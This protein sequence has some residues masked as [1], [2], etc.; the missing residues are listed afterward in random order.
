[1]SLKRYVL[2]ALLFWAGPAMAQEVLTV[3]EAL[4]LAYANNPAIM[5][6]SAKEE[7]ARQQIAQASAAKLPQVGASLLAQFSKDATTYGVYGP[8][9]KIGEAYA[10][11]RNAYQAALTLNWLIYSS[12]SVSNTVKARELALSGVEAQ[13]VR[14]GQGVE[15]GVRK[16]YYG[17]QRARAKLLVAEEALSLAKEHLTQV[18]SFY[19]YGVVAKDQVLRVQVDVSDGKLNV[20]KAANAVDVGWSAL[21]RA[22]G[23]S[24]KKSYSLPEPEST[25]SDVSVPD[26]PDSFAMEQRPELTALEFSRLSALS[27][28][29]A[30]SGT[31]G[32]QVAVQGRV[33]DTD[34]AFFP[35]GNDDWSVSLSASWTFFDGGESLAKEKE[36]KAAAQE[37]V[38]SIEDLK[39][40]IS[41]EISSGKLN[42][43][44]AIQRIEVARDQVASAE[45]D[46]RMALKRYTANVGTNIDVLDAR[47]ALSNARTQLVDAVYDTYT[48]RSDLEYA[49]GASGRFTLKK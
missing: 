35:S 44:S 19:R 31:R 43:A 36:A 23:T 42:L 11:Y 30:A 34:D 3:E 39:K 15:N 10:G 24:L 26:D 8:S 27:L 46:Y 5:A 25:V 17:L 13:S 2:L 1:M 4:N 7:Q 48:A 16:A 14:T 33:S 12:G 6:S 28:A 20:I 29:K 49:M 47:V 45:E 40:E 38:Y 41:M 22:V 9:G 32:P 37:L 18:E 21:E